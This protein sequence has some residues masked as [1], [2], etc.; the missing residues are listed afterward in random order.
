M[1]NLNFGQQILCKTT[2]FSQKQ[3]IK[4]I[5]S[6]DLERSS[7]PYSPTLGIIIPALIQ[8]SSGSVEA[9]GDPFSCSAY[10]WTSCVKPGYMKGWCWP[11]RA[12]RGYMAPGCPPRRAPW[13]RAAIPGWD[14]LKSWDL[15][16][17]TP[18][19]AEEEFVVFG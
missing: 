18:G 3:L 13:C 11:P 16:R 14:K 7:P 8:C 5:I 12:A 4:F 17:M 19:W 2:H 10:G 6:G 15:D 9:M 1:G